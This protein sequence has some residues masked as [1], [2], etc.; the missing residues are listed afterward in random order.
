MLTVEG[1][2][3]YYDTA[4]VLCGVDLQV[5]A[6]EVVGLLG[7]NGMG[8]T[9][10]VRSIAGIDPPQVREGKILWEDEDLV[11]Q[12][13]YAIAK[14][15]IGLVPQGRH[16]FGSLT[17]VENLTVAARGNG[18][19]GA[20]DLDE[21]FAFFPRLGDRLNSRGRNL[22]GGEQ[23]MLAIGRALGLGERVGDCQGY[24]C[25][26][27]WSSTG[28]PSGSS[29][30]ICLPPGPTSIS[31]RKRAPAPVSAVMVE[32]RFSTYSTTRFQPPGCC[33]RPFGIGREPELPG[34]LNRR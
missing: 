26:P 16:I 13:S 18:Q 29:T 25:G 5:S 20:W 7:R 17:V 31:F 23:Q 12:P 32:S 21:V 27:S 6:G 24:S 33:R 9:T 8:K 10:L 22:S 15:G 4:H 11:K 1:L 34:P 28:F 3:S 30:R 2:H 19:P 14:R